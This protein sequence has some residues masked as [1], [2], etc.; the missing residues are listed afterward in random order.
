MLVMHMV[1]GFAVGFV[2]VFKGAF[3]VLVGVVWC[4]VVWWDGEIG[5]E[6]YGWVEEDLGGGL[7]RWVGGEGMGSSCSSS[8]PVGLVL[9]PWP[10][11]DWTRIIDGLCTHGL[12][13][14][15]S[16]I[17][18]KFFPLL[19]LLYVVVGIRVFLELGGK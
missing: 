16:A 6:F 12:C 11:C 7:Y 5:L 4:G 3:W 9:C 10:R 17:S 19:G 2:E 14:S 13:A 18:L 15:S 1:V 8:F